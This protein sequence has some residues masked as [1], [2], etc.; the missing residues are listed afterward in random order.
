M[1]PV[2]VSCVAETNVV[3]SGEPLSRTCAPETKLLPVAVTLKPPVPVVEGSMPES[4]GVG[5][6]NVTLLESVAEELAELVA[7]IVI[8]LDV[9]KEAG[10]V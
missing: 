8:A 6:H 1:L 5:F 4:T 9:G 10:A 7:V 3:L 2:A